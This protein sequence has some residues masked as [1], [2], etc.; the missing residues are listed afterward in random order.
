[1]R[2]FAPSSRSL[3]A[4]LVASIGCLALACGD[5]AANGGNGAANTGGDGNGAANAGGNGGSG[6]A[7]GSS[8]QFMAGGGGNTACEGLECQ[9]VDCPGATTTSLS[10]TVYEPAG[11]TPLYNV[12]VYVPKFPAEELPPIVDGASCEPCAA[13]IGDVVAS[14]ITDAA[15]NFVLEDVPVGTDIPL[16]IQVGKWRRSFVIPS[17]AECVDTPLADTTIRLPRNQSEGHIPKIALTTGGA[18]PLE[19]LLPKIGLDLAEFTNPDGPGRVNLFAGSGGTS[20]FANGGSFPGASASL[21]ADVGQLSAY[22]VVLMACEGGQNPDQKPP[23]SLQAMVDYTALGGRVFASHWHNYWVQAGPGGFSSVVDFDFQPDLPSPFT[24]SVDMSFPKGLAL[25]QWLVNVGASAAQGSLVINEG[26]RTI[27]SNDPAVS[28]RWVYSDS[29]TNV[30]YVTFN[31]PVAAAEEEQCGRMVLSDIHVSSGDLIGQPF[32]SGC[33]T[34]ELS[35]QEKALLF[36]LFDLTA[37]LIPDDDPPTPP[38]PE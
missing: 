6:A 14:A 38:T 12:V 13:T 9:V 11:K 30:Q 29:P 20:Q 5:D 8:Q 28:T 19:C 31:T 2:T 3:T 32:P 17:V 35:P 23:T 24:A 1:M 27:V 21:W 34:T 16:V 4:T 33:V 25:A 36:M 7:A 37:C 26:Q 18:D 15:G 10:G 22:D